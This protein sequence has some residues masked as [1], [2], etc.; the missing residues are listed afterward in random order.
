MRL[1]LLV[2]LLNFAACAL[3]NG[4]DTM[5]ACKENISACFAKCAMSSQIARINR[6]LFSE[7][8]ETLEIHIHHDC[9]CTDEKFQRLSS[10]ELYE[11][12][13]RFKYDRRDC[14]GEVG[15]QHMI[16]RSCDPAIVNGNITIIEGCI[17]TKT[18][19]SF[20][21]F[22]DGILSYPPSNNAIDT[23]IKA[24]K[25][26]AKRCADEYNR[27]LGNFSCNVADPDYPQAVPTLDFSI[28]D[29]YQCAWDQPPIPRPTDP[30]PTPTPMPEPNPTLIPIPIPQPDEKRKPDNDEGLSAGAI[31]AIVVVPVLAVASI[32]GFVLF[33]RRY[34]NYQPLSMD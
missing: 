10:Q 9:R 25:E 18:P 6:C 27:R 17:N 11:V 33:R 24:R 8:Q 5:V 20:R 23:C 7:H 4:N 32:G 13:D 21:G 1:I 28:N 34:R 15:K 19:L 29:G 16:I 14:Q 31:A 12:C 22:Y 26:A 3:T 30:L 2:A